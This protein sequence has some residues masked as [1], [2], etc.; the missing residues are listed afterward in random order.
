MKRLHSEVDDDDD[1]GVDEERAAKRVRFE[2]VPV[3]DIETGLIVTLGVFILVGTD[4]S[5]ST[6][7]FASSALC[8]DPRHGRRFHVC[9]SNRMLYGLWNRMVKASKPFYDERVLRLK[10]RVLSY[11]ASID[12]Q[13]K[14]HAKFD[15]PRETPPRPK[16]PYG[17]QG[18]PETARRICRPL[19]FQWLVRDFGPVT[20]ARQAR[21]LSV[22]N[23][24][25]PGWVRSLV[26]TG[27]N[28]FK[29]KCY[30]TI[31]THHPLYLALRTAYSSTRCSEQAIM[32][33]ALETDGPVADSVAA[34]LF[35]LGYCDWSARRCNSQVDVVAEI[36]GRGL[37]RYAQE[38]NS[39]KVKAF[40]G[41]LTFQQW[42]GHA[43]SS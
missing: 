2:L 33:L 38:P 40:V 19:F 20:E 31:A 18:L 26:T 3:G 41:Y 12:S 7:W 17:W 30:G 1:S 9:L 4:E 11:K 43:L 34:G 25:F 27:E 35:Y 14:Q 5:T 21:V 36:I 13:T 15:W 42:E 39:D 10:E 24:T 16:S 37:V 8:A 23:T 32:A 6:A 29:D 22:L 28:E